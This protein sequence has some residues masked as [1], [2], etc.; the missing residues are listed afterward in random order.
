MRIVRPTNRPVPDVMNSVTPLPPR[1][2]LTDVIALL[3][4]S[5]LLAGVLHLIHGQ[6]LR[7]SE[8]VA[9]VCKKH[10][11]SGL[12]HHSL[13]DD[14]V[15]I[16]RR[17]HRSLLAFILTWLPFLVLVLG[18]MCCSLLRDA[19]Y[20]IFPWPLLSVSLLFGLALW[21]AQRIRLHLISRLVLRGPNQHLQATPR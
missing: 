14:L 18:N 5:L 15:S 21:V 4:I 2:S 6:K 11:D 16:V 20:L 3:A 17:F 19:G 8:E 1:T 13:S 10:S 7:L 9:V 12:D